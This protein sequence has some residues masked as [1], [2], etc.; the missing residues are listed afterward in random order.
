MLLSLTFQ[1][2]DSWLRGCYTTFL[3]LLVFSVASRMKELLRP[4]K[5][6]QPENIIRAQDGENFA[7]VRK[8]M[9]SSYCF[10]KYCKTKTSKT[11]SHG[12]DTVWVDTYLI[13]G[14]IFIL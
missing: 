7:K 1:K 12:P 8:N 6:C 4:V 13:S 3:S 14:C 11:V 5:F 10:F 9:P 2:W